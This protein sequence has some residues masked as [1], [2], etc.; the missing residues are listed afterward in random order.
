MHMD[1][2]VHNCPDKLPSPYA[3]P[4]PD[5]IASG[6]GPQSAVTEIERGLEAVQKFRFDLTYSPK[7]LR[8]AE[9]FVTVG[10]GKA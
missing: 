5:T 10:R 1:C 2:P 6:K 7:C 8:D 9:T 4:V 3:F